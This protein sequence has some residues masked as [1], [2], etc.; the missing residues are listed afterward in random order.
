M[1]ADTT[2]TQLIFFIAATVVATAAAGIMTGIVT[3]LV[4]KSSERATEFGN[5]LISEVKIINDPSKVISASSA[6]TFYVKNTGS[7]TLDWYNAT[8][9]VDGVVVSRTPSLLG[10]ETSFRAGAVAQYVYPVTMA[11]GDHRVSIS[12]EN[13]VHDELRFRI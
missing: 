6:T 4:D 5:E 2:S 9:L 3:D 7:T 12:M 11:S 10:G 13:G 8:L 1:G